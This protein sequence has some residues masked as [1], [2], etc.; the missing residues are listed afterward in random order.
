MDY[1]QVPTMEQFPKAEEYYSTLFH[2]M[3]HSTGHTS[4]LNRFTGAA[5]AAAFGSEE[6]SKEELIAEIGAAAL[7][8]RCGIETRHSFRNSAAYLQSWIKALRNDNTLIIG[9]AGKAEKAVAYI[10]TGEKPAVY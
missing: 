5:K 8:N 1:V 6:Y 4:R 2:E 7:V 9:A 10:L 3:T